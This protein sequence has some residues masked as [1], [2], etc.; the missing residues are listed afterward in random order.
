MS[1]CWVKKGK[2]PF[3]PFLLSPF[4]W[5]CGNSHH[6]PIFPWVEA[7]DNGRAERAHLR[8]WG[9][10]WALVL[11]G[12]THFVLLQSTIQL[13]LWWHL[14]SMSLAGAAETRLCP[15]VVSSKLA[16]FT[17]LLSPNSHHAFRPHIFHR[18]SIKATP[19]HTGF[20][21]F[22][23]CQNKGPLANSFLHWRAIFS[24]LCK[25]YKTVL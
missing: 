16:C 24:L 19:S 18:R 5:S 21:E 8:Q 1:V 11:W 10:R 23:H 2:H 6:L 9:C 13:S 4:G 12:I 7:G 22:W 3:P 20:P 14:V 17:W 25:P 15:L